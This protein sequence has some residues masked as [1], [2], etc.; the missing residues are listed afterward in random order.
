MLATV[1]AGGFGAEDQLAI[2]PT[3]V[4]GRRLSSVPEAGREPG[5]GR[6]AWT[7]HGTVLV[8][9]GLGALGAHT[10]RWLAGA[11]AE[12]LVLTGRRGSAT[13]GTAELVAELAALGA[14][15]TVAACDVADRAA[16]AN[17]LETLAAQGDS[18]NAVV[19]AAGVERTTALAEL[20]PAELAEVTAAKIA[21]A[22]HLDALLDHD[23]LEV[24]VSFSSVAGVW[25]SGGQ[26]AYAAANAFLDALAQRR[27]DRGGRASSVAWGPW[28]G[29]G[30]LA[31]AGASRADD[32]RRRGLPQMPPD[33][34]I[35]A[36]ADVLSGVPASV[37]VAD[38]RWDRFAPAFTAMRPG[39]LIEDLPEVR[40]VL[41]GQRD[42]HFTGRPDPV[43]Q[44]AGDPA[45]RSAPAA[46]PSISQELTALAASDRPAAVLDLV[47]AETALVLG[48]VSAAAIDPARAFRDLGF[49]SLTAVDLRNRLCARTGLP[50]PTT[51]VFDVPTPQELA[52]HVLALAL[53]GTALAEEQ[54]RLQ[55]MAAGTDAGAAGGAGEPIAI[56]AMSCRLPG[57]VTSPE[58]LWD[59]V[60]AGTDAISGFPVDRGW[61]VEGLYDP[62]PRAPG[63]SYVRTGGFLHDAHQFDADFFGISPREALA[64]DPQQRLL[65]ESTWE[66]FERAGIDPATVRGSQTGTF[67]GLAGQ[68][69]GT[70]VGVAEAGLEGHLLT[71]TAGSVASGRLA[72]TF[73]LEG[74]AVTVDTACSSSLVALHLAVR[75]LRSGECSLAV[76]GG[77]TVMS[78]PQAF[79]EFSRQRGL[80]PDGRCK[81]FAA[82]ADGT[83][84]AEGVGVLLVERLSDARRLGHPVWAVVRGSAVNSDGASNG[85]TAPNGPSQQR[86]IVRAL[87][88]ARLGAGEV[89]VVEAHGTGTTLG[90]PIEAQALLATY[91][92][93][94]D[95][96]RPLWV[97]SVKSNIGHT[98][99][100]SGLAG[101]IRTVMAMRHGTVPRTLHLDEPTPHVDWSAGTV[102]LLS[103]TVP[104]PAGQRP[105]RAGVSSFGMSGTN[106]HVILEENQD[107]GTVSTTGVA[108]AD[109]TA[110]DTG[111]TGVFPWV[112]SGRDAAGL[113]A[114]AGRLSAFVSGRPEL[115]LGDVGFSLVTGR[116]VF[117]H[118]AVVVAND[119]A[120]LLAGLGAL[121][122]EESAA[123]V[124]SGVAVAGAK[125]V[126]VFPGQGSQWVGMAV[127]LSA[128][129][130]VFRERLVECA[131]ALE[132]F[133]DWSLMEVLHGVEG[134]PGLGR[135]EVVQP[136]L[137]AVMVALAGLWGSFGV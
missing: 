123:G 127:E 130:P 129:F 68:D 92:Q 116:S 30:M 59:L 93:G 40:R 20:S 137:W 80:A 44:P 65:L 45:G 19:H 43:G 48:H 85:L 63:K 95:A 109:S 25:G 91:G 58:Q 122:R 118:R 38:V 135:V 16:V 125:P 101:V 60:A 115:G 62:D 134:A 114:Q 28:A 42:D 12:H 21:G 87:A 119:R 75:A 72:Y 102:R 11:G 56:V 36:L 106:V 34:A 17:L 70:R 100:L 112:V 13:P 88:D 71:G 57:D 104:W 77:A 94:R 23:A 83:G 6:P 47:R 89:D 7:P 24:N 86:V 78:T 107:S 10:A 41:A 79:V 5:A 99:G 110:D 52:A 76:V 49:D 98:A 126:F 82:A 4:F 55:L 53:G 66:V 128:S 131:A 14:C 96:D 81:P 90:D 103:E 39:P 73:G 35:T 69:Y 74:P 105:R 33:A 8:T 54:V 136:V 117:A 84:W 31:A 132:P 22:T 124:V 15:V 29:G 9:G 37:A 111:G 67:V 108:A 113:S 50:L 27:R 18:P 26:G 1:L 51:V 120:G 2:R 133:V 61:D 97:G 3:G 32:L 64:M 46:Q 121:S